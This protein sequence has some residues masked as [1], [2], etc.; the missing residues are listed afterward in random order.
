MVENSR[1]YEGG[2][3]HDAS[4]WY[5]VFCKPRSEKVAVRNL[6]RQGY[7]FYFP[8]LRARLRVGPAWR[9]RIA[10]LFPRYLFVGVRA[11]QALAPVR[12]TLGVAGLVRF[13]GEFAQVP[14]R[15]VEALRA[16]ADAATGL[17]RLA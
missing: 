6:A 7:S 3:A 8:E 16:R 9:D 14:E 12:S 10:P 11:G 5:L 2:A 17:H 1:S 13:G 15:V 4:C